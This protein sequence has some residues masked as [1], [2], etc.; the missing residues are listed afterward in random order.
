MSIKSSKSL[1]VSKDNDILDDE[2]KSG[3]IFDSKR[4]FDLSQ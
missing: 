1:K 2:D 4:S 3:T